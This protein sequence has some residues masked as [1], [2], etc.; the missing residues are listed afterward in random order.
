MATLK[1]KAEEASIVLVGSFNPRI[2]H[3]E[4][5]RRHDLISD[6]DLSD[7]VVEL[8]HNELSKFSLGWCQIEVLHERFVS[9]TNDASRF[10]ALRDLVISTFKI[11][12]HTPITTMGINR[13]MVY[14]MPSEDVWHHVGHKL[15]PK[16]IWQMSLPDPV[17]LVTLSVQSPRKDDLP[18]KIN[19]SLKSATE[20]DIIIDI[21]SHIDIPEDE[22]IPPT[23]ILSEHWNNTLDHA[24]EIAT[25]TINEASKQ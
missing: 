20:N 22:A 3:P 25:T 5:F 23:N 4:W 10:D 24:L 15:A 19:V 16:D 13:Q 7:A 18:G 21:N 2:F 6:H 8:V 9:R 1:H 14:S 17:G 12:E 11:L